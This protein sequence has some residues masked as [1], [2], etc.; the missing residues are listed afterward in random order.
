MTHIVLRNIYVF[1]ND[2]LRKQNEV[3]ENAMH[4]GSKHTE[5]IFEFINFSLVYDVIFFNVY[6]QKSEVKFKFGLE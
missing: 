6:C 2:F 3:L 4:L 1:R 5:L